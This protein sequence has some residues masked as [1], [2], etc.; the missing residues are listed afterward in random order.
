MVRVGKT[1]RQS[2]KQEHKSQENQ[3]AKEGEMQDRVVLQYKHMYY[4]CLDYIDYNTFVL[5]LMAA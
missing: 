1:G 2:M 5:W 3:R 4:Q